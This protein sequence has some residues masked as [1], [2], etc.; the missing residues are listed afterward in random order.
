MPCRAK[1]MMQAQRVEHRVPFQLAAFNILY[2]QRG[3]HA[4]RASGT[5]SASGPSSHP[6]AGQRMGAWVWS[7]SPGRFRPG[8]RPAVKIDRW[9][10]RRFR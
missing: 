7:F 6:L 9:D 2:G 3:D 1:N 5:H 10:E 4:T 8:D